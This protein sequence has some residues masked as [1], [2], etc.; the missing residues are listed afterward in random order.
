MNKYAE[1]KLV[2]LE[3]ESGYE[4]DYEEMREEVLKKDKTASMGVIIGQLLHSYW[5]KRLDLLNEGRD[6]RELCILERKILECGGNISP[7]IYLS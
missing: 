7:R 4:K 6:S 3:A 2:T 5:N 1:R